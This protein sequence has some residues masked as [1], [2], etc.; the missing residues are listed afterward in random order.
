MANMRI[1][2][3]GAFGCTRLTDWIE[4]HKDT[5]GQR[6]T[7]EIARRLDRVAEYRSN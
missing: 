7:S 1:A 6:Y 5:L 4:R 3:T 2:V